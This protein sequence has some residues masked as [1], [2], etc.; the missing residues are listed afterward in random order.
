MSRRLCQNY[1]L[2]DYDAKRPA[3]VELVT[4]YMDGQ[5]AVAHYCVPCAH[6]CRIDTEKLKRN[7]SSIAPIRSERVTWLT[8]LIDGEVPA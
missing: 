2:C 7:G 3:V 1:D 8:T 6:L 5:I 4:R